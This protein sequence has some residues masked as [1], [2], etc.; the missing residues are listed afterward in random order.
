MRAYPG[1][2]GTGALKELLKIHG[3]RIAR[4]TGCPVT[5]SSRKGGLAAGL[6]GM[7]DKIMAGIPGLA[8]RLIA[9]V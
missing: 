2:H 5:V 7:T 8:S 4:F 9:V 1:I 3:F 6:I